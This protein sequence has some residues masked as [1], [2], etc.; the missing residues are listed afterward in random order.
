MRFDLAWPTSN[1]EI[2][3]RACG[4]TFCRK[5]GGVWTSH[6]E[7]KLEARVG[8][9]ALVSRYRFGTQTADFF[10][11]MQCGVVPFVVSEIE[12]TDFAVVNT[13]TFDASD[14]FSFSG[15]ST[16]FDGEGTDDR[17]SRRKRNWIPHVEISVSNSE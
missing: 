6:R 13:N 16:S 15:S 11:C 14:A 7:A 2:A 1:R 4:C 5:H 10:V 3:T 8:N 12:N 9:A 17:L